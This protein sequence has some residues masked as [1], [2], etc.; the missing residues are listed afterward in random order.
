MAFSDNSV[1]RGKRR[2]F[3]NV[4]LFMIS[5]LYIV[6]SFFTSGAHAQARVAPSESAK[7]A[8]AVLHEQA[9]KPLIEAEAL[10]QRIGQPLLRVLDIRSPQSFAAGHIPGAL[11]APY[12]R[13]RGPASNPGELPGIDKLTDLVQSMGIS[14]EHHVVVISQGDDPTEFGSA[15][16]VYCTLK[17]L[18]IERLSLL[19][20][21]MQAWLER[22]LPLEQAQATVARSRFTAA[23]NRD[24][25]PGTE[26][27]RALIGKPGTKLIDARPAAYFLGQTRHPAALQAGTLKGASHIEHDSWFVAGSSRFISEQQARDILSKGGISNQSE[28]ISFCN[29]GHWAATNWFAMSEVLGHKNVKLY[30]GSMV[31]W[32]QQAEA[33]PMDHV[34]NRL[35][36]LLM[37]AKLWAD[38]NL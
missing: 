18:G 8:G 28:V 29:T 4:A 7:K 5:I 9:V 2:V 1:L 35:K 31:E 37:D 24:M 14:A 13:W 10:A 6:L 33:P 19:H 12:G 20:G 36:G 32:T 22:K 27:I 17:L 34:P 3:A 38:K 15:A 23:V 21:G 25:L 26:E 16:R 11:N 30:P